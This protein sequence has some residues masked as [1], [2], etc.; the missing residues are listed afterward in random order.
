MTKKKKSATTLPRRSPALKFRRAKALESLTQTTRGRGRRYLHMSTL[1]PVTAANL[2]QR[3]KTFAAPTQVM[4]TANVAVG[5]IGLGGVYASAGVVLSGADSQ[6]QR[7]MSGYGSA[8]LSTVI[9]FGG[10]AHTKDGF[11]PVGGVSVPYVSLG[12]DPITGKTIYVSV[13]GVGTV[14]VGSKGAVGITALMPVAP[15]VSAGPGVTIV[16][17]RLAK[18]TEP[19]VRNALGWAETV[20]ETVEPVVKKVIDAMATTPMMIAP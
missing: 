15:G 17:P 19:A 11:T 4:V 14:L 9:G 6:G 12:S 5:K 1:A 7:T 3:W 2:K 8:G 10:V 13:F 20:V 16:D 18:Y